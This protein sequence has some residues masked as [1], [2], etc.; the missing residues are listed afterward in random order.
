MANENN[1]IKVD[2]I[3]NGHTVRKNFDVELKIR[4]VNESLNEALK[5]IAAIGGRVVMKAKVNESTVKLGTFNVNRVTVDKN[6]NC[7]ISFM[8]NKDYVNMDDINGLLVEEIE[9]TLIAKIIPS[10]DE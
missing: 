10:I 5:F 3:Y 8:S 2:G 1:L 7:F 6:L 4:F 9:I